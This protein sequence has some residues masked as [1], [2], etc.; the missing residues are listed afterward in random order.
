M[1][2]ATAGFHA[3]SPL[4]PPPRL[5]LQICLP[6]PSTPDTCPSSL[7]QRQRTPHTTVHNHRTSSQ[8]P[9]ANIHLTM[10]TAAVP[11]QPTAFIPTQDSP[12][13]G[14]NLLSSL[15]SCKATKPALSA[16][17][18]LIHHSLY[19]NFKLQSVAY[20]QECPTSVLS[21]RV[22][23]TSHNLQGWTSDICTH[24]SKLK[25]TNESKLHL[26]TSGEFLSPRLLQFSSSR[27]E[28]SA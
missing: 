11:S 23:T 4:Y 12:P 5:R 26:S 16:A 10:L 9:A 18:N 24:L 20:Y 13:I 25:A 15:G 22:G 21:P 17:S 2:P 14:K 3:T 1:R 28:S 6:I 8:R 7:I 27:M 19:S